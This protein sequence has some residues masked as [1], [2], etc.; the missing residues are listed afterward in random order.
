VAS[1]LLLV[2]AGRTEPSAYLLGACAL[3]VAGAFVAGRA[4]QSSAASTRA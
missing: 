1:T 3:I 2:A 4:R